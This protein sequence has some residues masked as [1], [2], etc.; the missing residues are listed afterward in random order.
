MAMWKVTSNQQKNITEIEV[1]EKDGKYVEYRTQWRWGYVILQVPDK[2]D[3][4]SEFGDYDSFSDE[5]CEYYIEDTDEE[6]VFKVEDHSFSDGVWEEWNYRD[7]TAD[8]IEAIELSCEEE[9]DYNDGL[10]ELGWK[11]LRMDWVI[12]KPIKFIKEGE[13]GFDSGEGHED[14]D[15]DHDDF[16]EE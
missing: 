11:L 7:L 6:I 16:E 4:N 14:D 8:E 10:M 3:L 2:I 12:S 5:E 13:I 9:G 15:E 1:F